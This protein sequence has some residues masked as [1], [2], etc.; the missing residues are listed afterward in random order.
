MARMKSPGP[1]GRTLEMT[2][3]LRAR[4]CPGG[5]G[6]SAIIGGSESALSEVEVDRG[7]SMGA[8]GSDIVEVG[9]GCGVRRTTRRVLQCQQEKAIYEWSKKQYHV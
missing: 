3:A 4:S 1:H 8:M 5:A 2:L 6:I 7:A 9:N